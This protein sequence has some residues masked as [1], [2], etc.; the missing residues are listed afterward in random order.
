MSGLAAARRLMAAGV[1][2]L[3]LDKGRHAGGRMATRRAGSATFDHGAQYF[4][5][6]TAEFQSFV[7][8]MKGHGVL[9]EWWPG[10]S[11]TSHP[12]WIGLHG[13]NA[14]PKRM[15]EGMDIR[16]GKKAIGIHLHEQGW[17]VKTEDDETFAA[18]ALIITIPAPQAIDLLENSDTGLAQGDW[19]PLKNIA[20][21]PCLAVLATLD[22]PTGIVAPGG[23]LLEGGPISWLA[24]NFKKGISSVPTA[25]LHASPNFSQKHLDADLQA[26]GE[27]LLSAAGAWIQP[28]RVLDWHIHR[29]RYSLA[30]QRHPE[31]FWRAGTPAPLLFGGD[32]FGI[33]N[34]EGA[35]LSGLAMAGHVLEVLK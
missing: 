32:G 23:L 21:H 31:A 30:Y 3:L 24:D 14:L 15:A 12:R 4:S 13:M 19:A 1:H 7:A 34:V 25:T 26:A 8:K 33:G 10:I 9:G 6:K 20:Y 22:R 18:A 27:A 5:A 16:Q 17:L 28:A 35:F 29:W 2:C 11:D